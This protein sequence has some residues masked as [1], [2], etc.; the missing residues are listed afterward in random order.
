MAVNNGVNPHA[1]A[2]LLRQAMMQKYVRCRG[3]FSS[4]YLFIVLEASLTRSHATRVSLG[5][6]PVTAL[7]HGSKS[8]LLSVKIFVLLSTTLL[9]DPGIDSAV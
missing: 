9:Y 3:P 6:I 5:A 2:D 8:T 7:S 4:H 1:A